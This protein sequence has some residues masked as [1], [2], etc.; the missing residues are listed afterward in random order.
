MT[1]EQFTYWLQ[2]FVEMNP[3][4]MLTHTQWEILK[5]HLKLTMNKQTPYRFPMPS[6]GTPGITPVQGPYQPPALIC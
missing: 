1:P 6:I 2:G 5:D 3:E 4:A